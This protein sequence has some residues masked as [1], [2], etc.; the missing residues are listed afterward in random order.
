MV[1]TKVERVIGDMSYMQWT[2]GSWLK[3]LNADY[4]NAP[5][6]GRGKEEPQIIIINLTNILKLFIILTNFLEKYEI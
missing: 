2:C 6:K 5:I 4:S 1:K 3:V